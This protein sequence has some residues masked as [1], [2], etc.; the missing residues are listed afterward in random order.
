[1]GGDSPALAVTT[2]RSPSGLRE[3]GRQPHLAAQEHSGGSKEREDRAWD[4]V[5]S[6][7]R[8]LQAIALVTLPSHIS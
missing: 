1:M 8:S 3:P 4:A 6:Q 2:H 7:H 5:I